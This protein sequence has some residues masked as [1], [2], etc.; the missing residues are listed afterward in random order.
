MTIFVSTAAPCHSYRFEHNSR[1]PVNDAS[2][3]DLSAASDA[4]DY[5]GVG[6]QDNL[7]LR[8]SDSMFRLPSEASDL[9]LSYL[10]PGA[11]DAARH[12]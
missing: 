4:Q 11:L 8:T 1:R 2:T 3:N 12:N 5:H 7:L 9:I 6:H 10:S